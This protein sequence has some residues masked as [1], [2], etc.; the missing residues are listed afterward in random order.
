MTKT[1]PLPAPAPCTVTASCEEGDHSYTWPCDL[2]VLDEAP[3]NDAELLRGEDGYWIIEAL[4]LE[5]R[6]NRTTIE[7][8]RQQIAEL[9]R[10]P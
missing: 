4:A 1:A 7:R 10:R 2:A 6:C 5:V 8:L 3:A 9:E